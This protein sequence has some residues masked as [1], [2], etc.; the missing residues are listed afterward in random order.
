MFHFEQFSRHLD[1]SKLKEV[2]E[3]HHP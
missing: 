1:V 2:A 3:N